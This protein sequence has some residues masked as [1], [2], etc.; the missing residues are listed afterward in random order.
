MNWAEWLADFILV[1]HFAI[2]S[3]AVLGQLAIMIGYLMRWE[4]IRNPWFRL[5]HLSVILI[6]AAEAMVEFECPLTTWERDLRVYAGQIRPDFEEVGDW[7][8]ENAS[9]TARIIRSLMMYPADVGPILRTG[10]Y[11][12]AFLVLAALVLAP[13]RFRRKPEA[14][15]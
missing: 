8:V 2:V 15:G 4:W 3:F 5:A 10:Y 11:T 6:V 13:P 9:F 7:D 1:I 14:P 12:F